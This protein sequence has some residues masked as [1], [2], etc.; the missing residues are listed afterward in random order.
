[1]HGFCRVRKNVGG[2]LVAESYGRFAAMALD[3]IEKKPL[4]HFHPHSYI[5]SVGGC[6]C[7][8]RCKFC[9]N[10]E[11][12]QVR[13]RGDE[14]AMPPQELLRQALRLKEVARHGQPGHG[15][16]HPDDGTEQEGHVPEQEVRVPGQEV[17]APGQEV[18]VNGQEVRV[19]GQEVRVPGQEVRAPGQPGNIGVA[20]TYN[21]PLIGIEYI[22]DAAPLL[23][24]AGLK[25][26]VVSN[27]LI[28]EEP[29]EALLPWVDAWNIDLKSF[30]DPFY[31]EHGVLAA[32]GLE[33][34]KRSIAQAAPRAHLE[35]TTLIIPGVNDSPKE[36]QAM[37][38]WLAGISPQIPLHL[39]RF[40]PRY[41][42]RSTPPTPIATLREMETIAKRHLAH[43]HVGNV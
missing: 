2:A 21:E 20:F 19:P 16:G 30:A 38:R 40:F 42:M 37:S 4:H 35:V 26:V 41:Q 3:P 8:M 33:I 15:D 29:M 7:N 31:R 43:V 23:K 22:L 28:N 5:L 36:M 17:L 14:T 1:M 9:Q 25:V 39:S 11:I 34:V 10:H 18:R 6:S 24:K 32:G 13:S 12:S 27:G